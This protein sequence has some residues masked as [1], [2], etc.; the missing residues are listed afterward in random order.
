MSEFVIA[1]RAVPVGAAATDPAR[2]R[3]AHWFDHSVNNPG[4]SIKG[5]LTTIRCKCDCGDV[6]KF[7]IETFNFVASSWSVAE[8]DAFNAEL[9]NPARGLGWPL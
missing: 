8:R 6:D 1:F 5:I 3:L 9:R 7:V 2:V 4:E